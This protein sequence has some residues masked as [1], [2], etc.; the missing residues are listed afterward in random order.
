MDH[1]RRK[2]KQNEIGTFPFLF[3]HS[4]PNHR[5]EKVRNRDHLR[6]KLRQ[7]GESLKRGGAKSKGFEDLVVVKSI[8]C[9]ILNRGGPKVVPHEVMNDGE[10]TTPYIKIL[11]L[12]LN[13]AMLR[14]S[15]CSNS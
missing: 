4:K 13:V 10:W 3:S 8:G 1:Q 9:E 5:E 11:L 12:T 14:A 6:R 2:R 15:K 7:I